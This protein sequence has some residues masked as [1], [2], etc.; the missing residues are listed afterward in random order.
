MAAR[1]NL[2]TPPGFDPS[3]KW[4]FPSEVVLTAALATHRFVVNHQNTMQLIPRAAKL[5][6]NRTMTLDE[7]GRE[8]VKLVNKQ[9]GDQGIRH[10]C[11]FNLR[12][13][14][15]DCVMERAERRYNMMAVAVSLSTGA[16]F[17][18]ASKTM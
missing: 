10:L 7:M 18:L 16:L 9:S 15:Q 12:Q 13:A 17:Y 4:T 14:A 5:L 6:A 1:A 11:M 3:V 2:F 8:I